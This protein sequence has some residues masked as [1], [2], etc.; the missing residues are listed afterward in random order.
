VLEGRPQIGLEVGVKD[1]AVLDGL[2][3]RGQ[4]SEERCGQQAATY[5][6]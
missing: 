1:Q 6:S 3:A 5:R 4:G 2:S